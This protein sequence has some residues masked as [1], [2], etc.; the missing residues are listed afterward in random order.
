M[1]SRRVSILVSRPRRRSLALPKSR[2]RLSAIALP[3]VLALVT[4]LPGTTSCSEHTPPAV[5]AGQS[6]GQ[7][8]VAASS[9]TTALPGAPTATSGS[10]RPGL[11]LVESWPVETPLDHR[12]ISDAHR[13][14]VEMIRG[15]RRSIDIEQ[16]YASNPDEA[17]GNAGDKTGEVRTRLDDVLDAIEQ[18]AGRGVKVRCVFGKKFYAGTYPEIP[19]R[20]A[21][22]PGVEVRILDMDAMSGGVQHAKF[23]LIDGAEAYLGSQNLDWRSLTHIQELGLR[24]SQ[25][26]VVAAV[27]AL[28]ELDWNLAHALSPGDGESTA[29]AATPRDHARILAEARQESQERARRSPRFPVEM[30]YKGTTI[31]VTPGMSPKN[32]LPDESLWDLPMI[33]DMIDNARTRIRVQLLSYSIHNFDGTSFDGLD[34]ALR[35]AASRGVEVELLLADWNKRPRSLA[36][37]KDLQRL[38]SITV[39]LVTIPEHSGGFIPFARVIHSKLMT[40]DGARSWV[41]TSNWSGDYFHQSRNV[42][43]FLRGAAITADLDRFF[44]TGWTSTYATVLD[45]EAAYQPPRIAQ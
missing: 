28:F 14:W 9:P 12:D 32:W 41:G 30:E 20:L 18:A 39:K 33:L 29:I 2:Y 35:R 5:S 10:D 6:S 24:V 3:A 26:A 19:D 4:L 25:P 23:F 27:A 45:P 43:L 31:S 34:Q 37:L 36:T 16:F 7:T 11:A 13:A 38:P 40:V 17:Q 21:R 22:V 15:A 42:G 44:M 8:A 1:N